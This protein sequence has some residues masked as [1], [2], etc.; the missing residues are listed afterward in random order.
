MLVRGA[1]LAE[2]MSRYLIQ[3][4]SGNPSIELLCNSELCRLDGEKDLEEVSWINKQTGQVRSV[5]THHLFVMAGASPNTNWL[6]GRVALDEKGFILTGRDVAQLAI[7]PDRKPSLAAFPPT[8]HARKQPARSVRSWGMSG[9][10]ASKEW[11]RLLAKDLLPWCWCI[12]LS[13]SFS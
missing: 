1:D 6:Q 2:S 9:Q 13:R 10:E 12:E 5:S 8:L 11:L 4:I 3:R 7:D